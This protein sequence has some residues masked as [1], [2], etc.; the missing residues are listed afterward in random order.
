MAKFPPQL[1]Y[2]TCLISDDKSREAEERETLKFDIDNYITIR[3]RINQS[4]SNQLL[5]NGRYFLQDCNLRVD[6]QEDF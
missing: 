4:T 3:E 2:L 5:I 1:T 6:F